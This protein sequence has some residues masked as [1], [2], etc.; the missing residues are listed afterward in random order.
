MKDTI[1]IEQESSD[2][3][4]SQIGLVNGIM[5]SATISK[6][7]IKIIFKK[8]IWVTVITTLCL[9]AVTLLVASGCDKYEEPKIEY[10][11]TKLGER[12][13][14]IDDSDTTVITISEKSFNLFVGFTFAGKRDPF[15][16]K[17][18][19]IDD[20]LCMHI[21]DTCYSEDPISDPCYWR[22]LHH[23]TFDFVFKYQGEI[24]QKYKILLHNNHD[25]SEELISIISEGIINSKKR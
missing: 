19:I 11:K 6:N 5:E 14:Q 13:Y 16:T 24:N 8:P 22:M 3:R 15:E 9:V 20:V 17:V 18:E 7:G 1:R 2:M 10:L 12:P 25:D 4:S 21:I 23:Y